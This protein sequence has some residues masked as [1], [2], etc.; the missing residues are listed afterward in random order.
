MAKY[1]KKQLEQ[2][3]AKELKSIAKGFE[4]EKYSSKNKAALIKELT[5]KDELIKVQ[6]FKRRNRR[7]VIKAMRFS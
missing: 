1:T 7:P 5:G 3:N 2:L 6:A 4:I